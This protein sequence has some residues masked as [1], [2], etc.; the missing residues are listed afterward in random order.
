MFPQRMQPNM[1]HIRQSHLFKKISFDHVYLDPLKKLLETFD[2][3]N[4]APAVEH[5]SMSFG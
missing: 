1:P 5:V 2:A 3:W 4:I